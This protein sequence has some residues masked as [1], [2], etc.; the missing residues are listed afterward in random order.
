[1]RT[2]QLALAGAT[3]AVLASLSTGTLAIA[4]STL[5]WTQGG[6]KSAALP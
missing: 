5:Y 1:M 3:V 2:R 6:A 4:G